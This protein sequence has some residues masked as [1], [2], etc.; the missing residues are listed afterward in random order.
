MITKD[1][2]KNQLLDTDE[3]LRGELATLS[4]DEIIAM[5]SDEDI[6]SIDYMYREILL[7]SADIE[8]IAHWG[9]LLEF[10]L[11]DKEEMRKQIYNSSEAIQKRIKTDISNELGIADTELQI[12]Q[13]FEYM[14]NTTYFDVFDKWPDPTVKLHYTELLFFRVMS[15]QDIHDEFSAGVQTCIYD[16]IVSVTWGHPNDSEICT[17]FHP[18]PTIMPSDWD[19]EKAI[20]YSKT[21]PP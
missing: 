9:G 4:H 14:V 5:M 2:L 12:Y 8:G 18:E 10:G 6:Q 15:T 19:K 13:N 17:F 11:I 16:N 3:G 1:E 20:A 21:Q 7:R